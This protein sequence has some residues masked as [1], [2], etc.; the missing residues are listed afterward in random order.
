MYRLYKLFNYLKG[1]WYLPIGTH[2]L[3]WDRFGKQLSIGDIVLSKGHSAVILY[4]MES[5]QIEAFLLYSL[6]YGR[7]IYN[8]Y[9]YGKSFPI[10]IGKNAVE[11]VVSGRIK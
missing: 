10:K 1:K 5:R 8:Q 2:L 11:L 6:W 3:A 7:N 4:N 9:S